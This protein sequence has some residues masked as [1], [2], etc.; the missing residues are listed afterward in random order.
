MNDGRRPQHTSSSS[1]RRL[2][3]NSYINETRKS[4][5]AASGCGKT[6][7]KMKLVDYISC[8]EDLGW[9]PCIDVLVVYHISDSERKLPAIWVMV[10]SCAVESMSQDQPSC[11]PSINHA[12]APTYTCPHNL[13]SISA[14]DWSRV[15]P[16]DGLVGVRLLDPHGNSFCPYSISNHDFCEF[17]S[18]VTAFPATWPH[19]A[20][21]HHLDFE[22]CLSESC[23]LQSLS[24]WSTL[25][26][27]LRLMI[28][29]SLIRA[30]YIIDVLR[31]C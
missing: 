20:S 12:A 30:A 9:T 27:L 15:R 28:F 2:R 17:L 11:T 25:L 6:R 13:L 29:Y 10:L 16:S 8:P 23:H 3:M 26:S 5:L 22:Y 4:L 7:N 24:C 14:N 31:H 18:A 1:Y 21:C 19:V